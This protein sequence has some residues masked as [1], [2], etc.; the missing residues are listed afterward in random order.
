MY[1]RAGRFAFPDAPCSEEPFAL[2]R[3][4]F[5]LTAS[6]LDDP[7]VLGRVDPFV[8]RRAAALCP[9]FASFDD[10]VLAVVAPR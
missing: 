1:R 2:D 5:V 6:V 3:E 10:A 7:P 8:V 9:P 4:P